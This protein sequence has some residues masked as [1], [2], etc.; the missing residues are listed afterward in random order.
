MRRFLENSLL[1]VVFLLST[2]FAAADFRVESVPSDAISPEVLKDGGLELKIAVLLP[3][4]Y[5]GDAKRRYPVVYLLHGYGGD[6]REWERVGV[7]EEARGLEA[8]LVLPEGDRSFWVN[9]HEKPGAR[10]E[11]WV[12][13]DVVPW[14]DAHYRTIARREGR[15]ISG[16]SMGGYGAVILGLRHPELFASVASH[17]GALEVPNEPS[18]GEIGKRLEE[19]FGPRGS[20]P[21][22]KYDPL[23]VLDNLAPA[24]RPHIY[25]DCGSSDFLLEANRRFVRELS[26]RGIDYEYREV[27]GKHEFAYWKRNVR[28]SLDRQLEALARA[29]RDAPDSE[30]DAESESRETPAK[31]DGSPEKRAATEASVA[32]TWK[33]TAMLPD[34]STSDSTLRVTRRGEGVSARAEWNDG[35]DGIDLDSAVYRDERLDLEV[36]VVRDGEAGLVRV[37]AKLTRPG[38]LEGRWSFHDS[39]GVEVWSGDWR[40]ELEKA[41]ASSDAARGGAAR[42]EKTSSARGTSEEKESPAVEEDEAERL[43]GDWKLNVSI[44]GRTL[45][46]TLRVKK[47]G[48]GL[49]AVLVSPRSGDHPVRSIRWDDKRDR[50]RL[51]IDRRFLLTKIRLVCEGGFEDGKL[52]GVVTAVGRDDRGSFEATHVEGS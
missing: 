29:R 45:D 32:G 26:E 48:D 17:S 47:K 30:S 11:D 20:E 50:I 42:E 22:A 23:R 40:A 9:A 14:V 15:A 12:V 44:R 10:W 27:P 3:E 7:E 21:R 37:S 19:I 43:V 25:I 52:R 28:T 6:Y 41:E 33:V 35:E 13:R 24:D 36:E 39:S 8:I 38:R 5:D 4:G 51:E 34:G 16:L 1:L 49:D 46:Y 2:R 18:T 31:G